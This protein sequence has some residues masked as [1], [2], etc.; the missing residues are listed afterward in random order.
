MK[1]QSTDVLAP[2]KEP[3]A[4]RRDPQRVSKKDQILSLYTSGVDNLEDIALM[5]NSR[6]TYVASVLQ[7]AGLIS[8]YFDLYTTSSQ[9]MNAHSRFFAGKLSFKNEEAANRSVELLDRLSRQF[10]IARD[11]AGQHH[12][13]LMGLMMF[14]RAR[15][16]G[17]GQEA[18]IYRRWLLTQLNEVDLRNLLDADAEEEEPD[19]SSSQET[20]NAA[21]SSD[22]EGKSGQSTANE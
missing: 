12:A 21:Q 3:S 11:R 1:R 2:N 10:E 4:E 8:G 22:A 9:P 5:T 17:K 14:N 20:R 16:T 6:T 19:F 7:S 15:W 13:L 18:D